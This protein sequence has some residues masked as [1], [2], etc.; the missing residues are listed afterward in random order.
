MKLFL[1]RF[2]ESSKTK[3]IESQRRWITWFIRVLIS[4]AT[5]VHKPYCFF[6]FL[7]S[8]TGRTKKDIFIIHQWT[9]NIDN[10]VPHYSELKQFGYFVRYMKKHHRTRY[11]CVPIFLCS[12][13]FFS[14]PGKDCSLVQ[15]SIYS[16]H[17]CQEQ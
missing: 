13:F 7:R 3:H 6:S 5:S 12:F 17:T 9:N 1:F 8:F 16:Y 4:A 10:I 15:E 2:S 11:L 14:V